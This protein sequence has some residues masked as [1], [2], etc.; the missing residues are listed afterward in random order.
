MLSCVIMAGGSGTRLW[1]VSR[2]K[3][4]KQFLALSSIDTMLQETVNRLSGLDTSSPI[5]ICN[6]ENRFFVAEQL[7]AIDKLGPILLEPVGRNTAPAIALAALNAEPEDLLLVLA[8]DHVIADQAA[9]TESVNSALPLA[10]DGKLVTFGI[11]P[12]N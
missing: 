7:R 2:S 8:A 12:K 3:H 6:E 5:V 4:P 1:P 11:V 9:F 10:E